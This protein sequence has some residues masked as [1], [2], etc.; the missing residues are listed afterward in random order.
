MKKLALSSSR[1]RH[2]DHAQITKEYNI[3]IEDIN[4]E[5]NLKNKDDIKNKDD[6]K[7]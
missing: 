5:D 7:N 1:I 2:V 3:K 6:L 4:H